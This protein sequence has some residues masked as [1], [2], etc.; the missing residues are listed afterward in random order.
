MNSL[1]R[2]IY[3]LAD[4][5]LLFW[6][7]NGNSFM[8]SIKALLAKEKP[9]AAYIGASNG[10][11]LEFYRLFEGVMAEAGIVDCRMIRASFQED[12]AQFL[13]QADLILLAGGDVAQGWKVF[14]ETGM[15]DMLIRRHAE[16]AL[17]IGVF[18]G[19]IHLGLYGCLEKGASHREMF[20]TLGLVPFMIDVHGEQN[21][22]LQLSET[23]ELLGTDV[24]GI[25]IPSGGGLIYHPDNTVEPVR[26]QAMEFVMAQAGKL[27]CNLL[28]PDD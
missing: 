10:D 7:E 19:A 13:E 6:K 8:A 4:S 5:Q 20:K 24:K 9:T 21:E 18:A 12:D 16:G 26:H 27:A 1:L 25:G 28:S 3:L 15:N 22:W 23:I 11:L 17:L 14:T 2:P